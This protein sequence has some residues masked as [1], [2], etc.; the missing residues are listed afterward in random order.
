MEKQLKALGLTDIQAKMYLYL[1]NYSSGRKPAQVASAL[2]LTRTNAY[3]ILDQLCEFDLVKKSEAS[4]TYTYFAENPIALTTFV[5]EARQRA[6]LLEKTL[7]DSLGDLQK[8]Y[9]KNTRHADVQ[10]AHGKSAIIQAYRK[11][12]QPGKEIFFVKSRHDIS[13]MGHDVMDKIRREA[14]QQSAH[15][16][17]ITVSGNE[18]P[19]DAHADI[20]TKLTRTLIA[21][22]Q[23]TSPVEWSVCGNQLAIISLR[24]KGSVITIN[25]PVVADSFRELWQLMN[26]SAA[27]AAPQRPF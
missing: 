16:Y 12:A 1:L 14:G 18:V 7:K 4:K 24:D 6:V 19:R 9:Q 21:P 23:Y 27:P 25:D 10:T 8:K 26:R 2:G 17:G 15:R 22:G 3:K 20:D 5:A 13:F 11:Q